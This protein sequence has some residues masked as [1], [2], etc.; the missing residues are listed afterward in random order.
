MH[1]TLDANR[2]APILEVNALS[3]HG[4]ERVLVDQLSFELRAGQT[5]ALV[6]ESGSGKSV[7]ALALMGLLPKDLQVQG[8]VLLD[9]KN[10]LKLSDA[11]LRPIRGQK[12]AMVFQEPMTALNS[13]HRV[14][15]IIAETLWSQGWSKAQARQ[16]VIALLEDVGIPNPESVLQRFPYELSGGQRQRVMIAMALVQEPDILIADEPTTA[17]DVM[18]QVQILDLLKSLQQ[19]HNMAMILISHDLNLVKHYADDVVV[20]HQGKVI[21]QGAVPQ[22]FEQSQ[23]TY[24]QNLLNH[25][26][27]Q[28]IN[29]QD[30]AS[31][32]RLKQLE[33]KFPIKKGWFNRTTQYLAAQY[34]AAV[35]ALDLSLAQGHS[36]GIVGESGA[37]KSSLALA[38]A[39]LIESRGKIQFGE[40]DLNQLS[41]KALRPLRR[42]FQIVFQDPFAS[43][44]PRMSVEQ[45]IAE[46]LTL[47]PLSL[48]ERTQRIENVLTQVE[49]PVAFKS[50]YPHELSGGQRQRVALARALVL[51]PKLLILDEPTSA[52]DRSTQRSIVALLRRLQHEQGISYLF[53]SHDLQVVRALCQQVLVLRHAKVV[54]LQ[55]TEQ[56]FEQPQ[57]DYTRQLI[58]ASQYQ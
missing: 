19:R 21:E 13:L 35:E 46:G 30:A 32:L 34:L 23:S 24:T 9:G 8:S 50:Y 31:L 4:S 36:L 54:E 55:A 37:G 5:L 33:V 57:S 40:H 26:F 16:R 7:S 44:N 14:E 15:K 10:L 17:L 47:K 58:Q 29:V 2:T 11:Q 1:L 45:I 52:L 48:F 27:G 22:I 49:L 39:R 53:I 51:Q 6:G 25:S 41:Q 18:L 38:V 20:I 28:A 12:I 43:L 42:D 56:L 3:I